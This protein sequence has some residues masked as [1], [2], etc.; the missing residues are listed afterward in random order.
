MPPKNIVKETIGQE[1]QLLDSP[2][3]KHSDIEFA[4]LKSTKEKVK[5]AISEPSLI[6]RESTLTPNGREKHRHRRTKRP[7][8]PRLPN[9]FGYEIDDL[10]AF[11]TKVPFIFHLSALIFY[12]SKL[13][14]SSHMGKNYS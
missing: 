2:L 7:H 11:L 6:S 10:D 8:K 3:E 9:R 1:R 13:L 14:Y 4:G 12:P 5:R